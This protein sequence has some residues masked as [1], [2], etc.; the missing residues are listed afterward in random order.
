M[1]I[2]IMTD[3]Q[4]SG[5]SDAMFVSVSWQGSLQLIQTGHC[6]VVVAVF[7]LFTFTVDSLFAGDEFTAARR[8]DFFNSQPSRIHVSSH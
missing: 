6:F 7:T 8:S 5:C 1:M 2:L 4:Y 3:T